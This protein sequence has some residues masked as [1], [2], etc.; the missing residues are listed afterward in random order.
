[1][2]VRKRRFAV[3]GMALVAGSC[4]ADRSRPSPTETEQ[5]VSLTVQLL[6]PRNGQ[7]V[8]GDHTINVA[9]LG[10]DLIGD[11]LR[12]VGFVARRMG[13]GPPT[14]LDSVAVRPDTA[15][16][17]LQQEFV[18]AVPDL[19]TN[20]QVDVIGIAY[21]PGTETRLSGASS[22]IVIQC[23]PGIPGC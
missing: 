13:S 6:E 14:T 8:L 1:M 11:G 4:Y 9:V 16:R 18:F 2:R 22:L 5:P 7:A 15:T 21:G 19:P 17:S 3:L 10:R 20:T 23:E 12:G